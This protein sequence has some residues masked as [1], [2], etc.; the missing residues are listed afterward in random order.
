MFPPR[1]GRQNHIRLRGGFGHEDILNNHQFQPFKGFAHR[2]EFSVGLQ[3]IFTHDVGGAYFAMLDAVRQLADAVT[4]MR[5]Q[6]GHAPGFGELLTVF[7][8]FNVLVARIGIRQRAHIA[9]TLYVVLT[10]HRVNTHAWPAEVA[11]QQRQAGQGAHGFHALI[12]LGNAHA[13]QNGG[14]ARLRIHPGGL[15]DLTGAD[16]SNVFDRFR[17]I[18]FDNFAIFFEAFGPRRDKGVVIQ[19]FFDNHM[20]H[21]V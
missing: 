19:I 17:R 12:E 6:L 11:G 21:G 4:G 14:I 7:R 13:P 9:R 2:R 20:A 3:R 8:E 15:A 18:A 10:T 16:A 5:R 1:G